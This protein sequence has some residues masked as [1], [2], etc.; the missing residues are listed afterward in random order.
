MS[1]LPPTRASLADAHIV[2]ADIGGPGAL[3]AHLG[4]LGRRSCDA[5]VSAGTRNTAMPGPLGIGGPGAGEDDEQT[6]RRGV[7]DV[8]LLVR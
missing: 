2:E 6:G 4:V 3:L 1:S 5:R 8:L 7:G